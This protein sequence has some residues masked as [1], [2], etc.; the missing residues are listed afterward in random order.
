MFVKYRTSGTDLYVRQDSCSSL[1]GIF[2]ITWGDFWTWFSD[3]PD[4]GRDLS[5][6]SLKG[7][8][9]WKTVWI[10]SQPS[11]YGHLM[12]DKRD[13]RKNR[14][15][16]FMLLPNDQ[17]LYSSWRWYGY[18]TTV[19]L[20]G[21]G[22]EIQINLDGSPPMRERPRPPPP[23]KLARADCLSMYVGRL[24]GQGR[25]GQAVVGGGFPSTWAA[26]FSKFGVT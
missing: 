6:L 25:A 20:Q 14:A 1:K 22:R 12:R 10:F 9:T 11:T 23:K 19:D 2:R 3:P 7:E 8:H 5:R 24:A 13:T 21:Q 26:S 18:L 15:I 16:K 17:K 4:Q